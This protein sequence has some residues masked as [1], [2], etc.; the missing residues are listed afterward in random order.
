MDN[1]TYSA[2]ILIFKMRYAI[3]FMMVTLLY[4]Y[5]RH[6]SLVMM[7]KVKYIY[8]W[9]KSVLCTLIKR[10]GIVD[11]QVTRLRENYV[12]YLERQR[13]KHIFRVF[14]YIY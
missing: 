7:I 10:Q 13:N 8:K 6:F 5:S 3:F 11:N 4:G 9:R 1:K 12:A 2:A 14:H